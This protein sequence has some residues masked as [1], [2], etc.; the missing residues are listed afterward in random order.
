[1]EKKPK[2][3]IFDLGTGK[4]VNV[5]YDLDVWQIYNNCSFFVLQWKLLG[6]WFLEKWKVLKFANN[7]R[8]TS[9]FER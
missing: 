2:V 8:M 3:I 7:D 6:V 5:V 9:S 4:I 1:M